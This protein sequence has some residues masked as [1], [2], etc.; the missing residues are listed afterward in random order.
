MLYTRRDEPVR[1]DARD[2]YATLTLDYTVSP[3]TNAF[4]G[5]SISRFDSEGAALSDRDS[6]SVFLGLRHRF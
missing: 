3:Q 1:S 6:A 5:V 2:D 4:A